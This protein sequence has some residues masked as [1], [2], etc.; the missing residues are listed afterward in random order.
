[1]SATM[2]YSVPSIACRWSAFSNI[3]SCLKHKVAIPFFI[4]IAFASGQISNSA[5]AADITI[6]LANR[7]P[8]SDRGE[9]LLINLSGYIEPGDAKQFEAAIT[10]ALRD[11]KQPDEYDKLWSPYNYTRRISGA[12]LFYLSIAAGAISKRH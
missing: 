4:I 7:D 6:S 12:M 3:Q 11:R 10:K 9:T 8:S 5:T 2:Y 1:M